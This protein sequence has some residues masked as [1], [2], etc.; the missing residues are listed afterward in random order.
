MNPASPD[1]LPLSIVEH[2]AYCPRQAALIHVEGIWAA[3][4]D[5]ALGEA[6]HEAV[7]RAT[8]MESRG[9]VETWLS[10]PVWHDELG[11]AGICD[12]VE[13]RGGVPTPIEYKPKLYERRLAPAAQQLAA[14]AMCL[15]SMWRTT[16]RTAILFTQA[17]RRRHPI[18]LDAALREAT[19]ETIAACHDLV[20]H[21]Q[22]STPVADSR[23]HRCSV[24]D[25]CGV[26]LPDMDASAPFTLQA[27]AAW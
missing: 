13:V 27:E 25:A 8:K 7:D 4:A 16:V 18:P 24:S 23:C 2:Y 10:L 22:L 21:A 20:T 17:D 1:P 9:G 19:M 14:Q 12:A 3:N 5:T 6:D 15:E 11:I 26:R